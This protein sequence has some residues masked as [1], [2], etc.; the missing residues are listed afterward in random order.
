VFLTTDHGIRVGA[1]HAERMPRRRTRASRIRLLCGWHR[2]GCV[3]LSSQLRGRGSCVPSPWKGT[4]RRRFPL[5]S[6]PPQ[7]RGSTTCRPMAT[8][9]TASVRN[10]AGE[11]QTRKPRT[12]AATARCRSLDRQPELSI[13]QR[14]SGTAACSPAATVMPS[15][16]GNAAASS[17]T[18]GRTARAVETT[19]SRSRTVA[20]SSMSLSLPRRAT[21]P[22][23]VSVM[24]SAM[25]IRITGT[26]LP[27]FRLVH[28]K[29]G[30]MHQGGYDLWQRVAPGGGCCREARGKW[31]GDGVLL[32]VMYPISSSLVPTGR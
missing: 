6:I 30:T 31:D 26:I 11:S 27:C 18:C 29:R 9:L 24:G 14:Q 2:R 8:C 20:A 1:V 7:R 3:R 4:G 5:S 21:S 25:S 19:S 10:C 13:A 15:R 22:S 17:A 23:R 28:G 32:T 16:S 12:P